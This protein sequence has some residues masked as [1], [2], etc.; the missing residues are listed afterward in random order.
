MNVAQVMEPHPSAVDAYLRNGWALVPI[1]PR[2]KAPIATG[3]NERTAVLKSSV[4]LPAGWNLGLAHAYSG[5][6]AI[7]IDDYTASKIALGFVGIDL[8]ALF[9]APDAVTI[10]SGRPGHAKLIYATPF[11][12]ALPSRKVTAA[13][14]AVYDLRCATAN[15]LTVQDVLPP[16][17]H[18]DTGQPYRWGGAGHWQRLPLL[19]VPLL[20]LW[21]SLLAEPEALD[22]Q[23]VDQASD[24]DWTEIESAMTVLD[25]NCG[26][27]DWI[28]IGF[29]LHRENHDRGFALWNEWSKKSPKY[30]GERAMQTQ[31]KSFHADKATVV[32][33]G[34]L[35]KLAADRGWKKPPVDVASLF[36]NVLTPK[37]VANTI[38]PPPP[39]P[40]LSLFP[41]VLA[42]RA[43]EVATSIG[44]DPLVPLFAGLAAVCSCADARSR[45]E[46]VHGFEVP[47]VLW[48]MTI[49]DPADKKT[50]GSEP[51]F[52]PLQAI[53]QEDRPRF[54]K[55]RLDWEMRQA[56]WAAQKKD[57]LEW[58][59]SDDARL[60]GAPPVIV[61]EPM[62]PVPLRLTVNDITSQKL[63]RHAAERPDGILCALD[64]MSGWA[65][66]IGDAKTG[67]D[68]SA[69][70]SS[71][72]GKKYE[73]DRV[74]SGTIIADPFAVSIY[75]NIQPRV[76]REHLPNLS[77]DGLLQRF[78]PAILDGAHTKKGV[79]ISA[80][81][82]NE[83]EWE[84][85]LRTVFA[86]PQ[87]TYTL[88][89]EAYA[90]FDAFQSWYDQRRRDERLLMAD[91]CYREALGKI[92]G[93]T[94]RMA[95][96]LHLIEQPFGT[97]VSADTMTR[98]VAFTKS[99][100]I[101]A[102]RYSLGEVGGITSFDQW[103]ADW[104]I[105]HADMTTVTL[106]D[107][108]RASANQR[109]KANTGNV[110]T[111]DQA[112]IGAMRSIEQAGWAA[113]IDDGAREH[114]HFAQWAVN[115]ALQVQFE[116]HRRAI[117]KAHERRVREWFGR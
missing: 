72:N 85:L 2:S 97:M 113:R 39:K 92:E 12:M 77:I 45:L 81:E 114:Q 108:K 82:S 84:M 103:L 38:R 67:E 17:L 53:E 104:I 89:P 59:K 13:K 30:P 14:Y 76:Y 56:I 43:A 88:S 102:L 117:A 22:R 1:P 46:I 21:Q 40:D 60:G 41:A 5:T 63:V 74:G 112:I 80:S 95:L 54:A 57:S 70:T 31:W 10:D 86:L 71:Y 49:G 75:G 78:V 35:F 7:D 3:W 8:D 47:P 79:P 6:C 4:D 99:Y 15:G 58:A 48:L 55:A 51:M 23:T 16:S 42:R 62:A 25:A 20:T 24:T 109:S 26:R 96:V 27:D 100:V 18:P 110:W 91:D 33:L 98:A 37:M 64:E 50:P 111:A 107:I 36:S 61:E 44:C 115:P 83:A 34:T 68:R 87:R 101:P 52:R 11:G 9:T 93:T 19:P 66:K 105:A 106:A 69:W 32:T 28:S 94:G 29:A 90:V 116:A 65:R 73:M